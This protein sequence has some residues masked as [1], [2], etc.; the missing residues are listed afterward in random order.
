[1]RSLTLVVCSLAIAFTAFAQSDRGTITGTIADPAGAVV[2]GASI[3][4]R[5]WKTDRC[6]SRAA[7][8][9]ATTLSRCRPGRMNLPST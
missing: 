7:P 4:V 1:M 2:A 8:P 6:T 9:L 3:E 5:N